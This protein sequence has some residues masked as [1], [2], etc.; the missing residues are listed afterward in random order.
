MSYQLYT[1]KEGIRA[2]EHGQHNG[3]LSFGEMLFPA[4]LSEDKTPA[5]RELKLWRVSP[6]FQTLAKDLSLPYTLTLHNLHP[7]QGNFTPHG[8]GE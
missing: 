2:P 6:I 7:F 3:P 5:C 1:T 4:V 8:P